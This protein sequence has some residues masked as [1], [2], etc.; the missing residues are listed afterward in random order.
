MKPTCPDTLRGTDLVP[1]MI[2]CLIWWVPCTPFICVTAPF[3]TSSQQ[4]GIPRNAIALRSVAAS[5]DRRSAEVPDA[6]T[7][8][9]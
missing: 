6:E 9:T 2:S 8:G 7:R 3:P 5:R 1:H 4:T